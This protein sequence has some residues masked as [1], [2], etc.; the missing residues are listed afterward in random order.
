VCS[1][2]LDALAEI[3]SAVCTSLLHLQPA[4]F[5]PQVLAIMDESMQ[6]PTLA[7]SLN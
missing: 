7:H 6:L 4:R 1:S 2:D 3:V 5:F